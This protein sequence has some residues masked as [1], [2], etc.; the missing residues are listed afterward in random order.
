MSQR[1][2]PRL[3]IGKDGNER[4]CFTGQLITLAGDGSL[5]SNVNKHSDAVIPLRTRHVQFCSEQSQLRPSGPK[6]H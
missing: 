3:S 2:I 6:C 1:I 5:K 4:S